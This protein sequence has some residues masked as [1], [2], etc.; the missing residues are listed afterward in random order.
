[1]VLVHRQ[2]GFSSEWKCYPTMCLI[3]VQWTNNC[4]I[5]W[6][7]MSKFVIDGPVG[8]SS[9]LPDMQVCHSL[10]LLYKVFIEYSIFHSTVLFKSTMSIR[11]WI[12]DALPVY[13]CFFNKLC[14]LFYHLINCHLILNWVA[15]L[16]KCII[17][18][19]LSYKNSD[20]LGYPGYL[21]R[22]ECEFFTW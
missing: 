3:G 16:E 4:Q 17:G 11:E 13:K 14:C 20:G 15:I 2:I 22:P 5:F 21:A 8:R 9:K 6:S 7:E 12:V 1:V 19:V 18:S 10:T